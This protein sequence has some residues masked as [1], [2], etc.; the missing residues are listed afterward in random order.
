MFIAKMNLSTVVCVCA[1]YPGDSIT[2]QLGLSLQYLYSGKTCWFSWCRICSVFCR[3]FWFESRKT[4]FKPSKICFPNIKKYIYIYMNILFISG[5]LETIVQKPYKVCDVQKVHA[6][7]RK[8]IDV[9][10]DE[11]ISVHIEWKPKRMLYNIKLYFVN[12]YIC[13]YL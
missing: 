2:C 11:E 4:H 5:W 12:M 10:K 9:G 1:T 13:I 8:L 6:P 7:C 3:F